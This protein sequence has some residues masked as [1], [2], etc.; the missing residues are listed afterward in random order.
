MSM[1]IEEPC[2]VYVGAS[3]AV[4]GFLGLYLADIVLNFE[5]MYRPLLRLGLMLVALGLT[6]GVEFATARGSPAFTVSHMSHIGGLVAGLF[7]SFIF[8]PNFRDRRWRSA[9][10]LAYK[11]YGTVG[12]LSGGGNQR[13]Q[14]PHW[15]EKMQSCWSRNA[16]LY[17][18]L[19][20]LSVLVIIAFFAGFPAYVWVLRMPTTH[21]PA[22][23]S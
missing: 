13:H 9:R 22:L 7:V 11:V 14:A 15:V 1:A 19:W 5:S 12:R 16:W 17:W 8:L 2:F 18:C 20:V 21:C 10:K 3:G 23:L 4:F 6:L